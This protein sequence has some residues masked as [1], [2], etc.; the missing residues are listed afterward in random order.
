MGQSFTRKEI[1]RRLKKTTDERRPIIGAGC[2]AGIIAKCAELG[3]ADL[4]IVYSTGLSRIKGL[5]TTMIPDSNNVTIGMFDEIQNVVKGTPI[6]AG[7]DATESPTVRDFTKLVQRFTT[8]GFSG[9]INF[10]TV[11]FVYDEAVP[12]ML[13][14]GKD[15]GFAKKMGGDM[16]ELRKRVEKGLDFSIEV[17]M[18]R[19]CRNTDVF[20]MAYVF[21]PEQARAMAGAGV[22][23]MVC[24]VGGTGGG[25]TGFVARSYDEA[26][27]K[28]QKMIEATKEVNPD[29]I[30]LGHGGPFATPEDTRYLYELT[31]AVGFVGASSI[32]RIP[33]EKAIKGVLE[34][35]KS[36][37][38]K[39]VR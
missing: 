13:V 32:E 6:I 11:G 4:I 19:I 20:T 2:S 3:G 36:I 29:I 30:C 9:V 15:Q 31:D 1:L 5:P 28:A 25:L 24:H 26:A 27:T 7:I 22:D 33:V 37:P 10:P 8:K 18:I 39:K 16:E 38:L 14:E 17:E 35:Y 12:R 23:V 34:E 21:N